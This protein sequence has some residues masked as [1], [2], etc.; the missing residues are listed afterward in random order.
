MCWYGVRILYPWGGGGGWGV[1][2]GV[3]VGVGC[4]VGCGGGGGGGLA[5]KKS[6]VE[7]ARIGLLLLK[8]AS[9]KILER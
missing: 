1:G 3:G 6:T 2:V 4:G 9:V 8:R 5:V 7:F